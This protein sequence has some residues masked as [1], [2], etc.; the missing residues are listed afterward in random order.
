MNDLVRV[1]GGLGGG[2]WRGVAVMEQSTAL[3]VERG[4]YLG[5]GHARGIGDAGEVVFRSGGYPGWNQNR[6]EWQVF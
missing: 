2:D 1:F 3:V 4:I 5:S 6:P